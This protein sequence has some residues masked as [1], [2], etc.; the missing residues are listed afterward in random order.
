MVQLVKHPAFGFGS[1]SDLMRSSPQSGSVLSRESC[2][3]FSLPLPLPLP[4][5]LYLSF[6]KVNQ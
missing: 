5:A 6:S 3:R 2:L 4:H 1:G